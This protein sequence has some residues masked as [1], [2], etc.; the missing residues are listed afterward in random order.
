MYRLRRRCIFNINIHA[1]WKTNYNFYR[2]TCT[3]IKFILNIAAVGVFL[4]LEDIIIFV[5]V[6]MSVDLKCLIIYFKPNTNS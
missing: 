1:L 5:Y 4:S 2:D 6:I 3:R